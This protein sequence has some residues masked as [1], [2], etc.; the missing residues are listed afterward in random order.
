MFK[1]FHFENEE[2]PEEKVM[3]Y[4]AEWHF[5]PIALTQG[6]FWAAFILFLVFNVAFVFSLIKWIIPFIIA[7]I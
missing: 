3:T 6:K 5:V 1:V 2:N 4:Q 7:L